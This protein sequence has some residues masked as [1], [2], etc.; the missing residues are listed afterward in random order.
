MNRTHDLL[1]LLT[2]LSL[3]LAIAALPALFGVPI[4]HT[5]PDFGQVQ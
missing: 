3:W 4:Q 1:K 5:G 2:G